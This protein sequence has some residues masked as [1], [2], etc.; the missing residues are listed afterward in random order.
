MTAQALLSRLEAVRETKPNQWL[1]RCPAHG[2]RSPSLSIRETSDGRIL[3]HC[4]AGCQVE[5]VLGI[6]GLEISILFPESS[7][8][9]DA[10]RERRPFDPLA[11]LHAIAHEAAVVALVAQ[12]LEHGQAADLQRLGL[13]SLRIHRA[14]DYV[15][16]PQVPEELR[17]IRRGEAA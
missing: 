5:D 13:A 8:R 9:I 6:L 14:L 16:V 3:V 10:V 17:R 12:A 4:F 11:V 1:A 2:D 15:G 7:A